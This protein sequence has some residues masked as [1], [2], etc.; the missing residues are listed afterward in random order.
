MDEGE[1]VV[2]GENG[3]IEKDKPDVYPHWR[4]STHVSS[5]LLLR[6]IFFS[7]GAFP[8]RPGSAYHSIVSRLDTLVDDL[9]SRA[10]QSADIIPIGR[11]VSDNLVERQVTM[12]EDGLPHP[13]PLCGGDGV[14]LV[15]QRRRGIAIGSAP[16]VDDDAA[17]GGGAIALLRDAVLILLLLLL[18]L[19]PLLGY[20]GGGILCDGGV[21][22]AGAECVGGLETSQS[23]MGSR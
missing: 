22:A 2:G 13:G 8:K 7:R 18:L 14:H 5:A 23:S 21:A 3:S 1:V 19:L 9:P 6:R 11:T 16:R 12:R 15:H 4:L 17:L 10:L 20:Q